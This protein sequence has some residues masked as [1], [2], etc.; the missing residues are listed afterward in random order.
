M[1]LFASA[2][3]PNDGIMSVIR[4]ETSITINHNDTLQGNQVTLSPDTIVS[5][6][7]STKVDLPTIGVFNF[8][9][10][11][12]F[13]VL[14]CQ[15]YEDGF[16]ST[17]L[18]IESG[19]VSIE[20]KTKDDECYFNMT[21]PGW[22][23]QLFKGTHVKIYRYGNL[24]YVVVEKE[25]ITLIQDSDMSEQKVAAGK[26]ATLFISDEGHSVLGVKDTT[27]YER[28]FFREL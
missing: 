6:L 18:S 10:K 3:K 11:S 26:T 28:G 8:G 24:A 23:I 12:E 9:P 14:N 19:A 4:G 2:Q 13:M 21:L 25:H 22:S 17:N 20:S 5:F 1:C 16:S 27:D 7:G 15:V